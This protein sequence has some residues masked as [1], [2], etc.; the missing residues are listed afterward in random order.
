MRRKVLAQVPQRH[1]PR[2]TLT[3]CI[4]R[5]R[6]RLAERAITRPANYA[7][8]RLRPGLPR[9]RAVGSAYVDGMYREQASGPTSL[10]ALRTLPAGKC[11]SSAL[12]CV[13]PFSF[14]LPPSSIFDVLAYTY[15]A[16]G[17]S[18]KRGSER[19]RFRRRFLQDLTP[20]VA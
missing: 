12:A 16:G 14:I 5:A 18:G 2:N 4:E 7:R 8:L 1:R 20:P 9:R 10:R 17:T 3:V 11:S 19:L 6:A 15:H 13:V